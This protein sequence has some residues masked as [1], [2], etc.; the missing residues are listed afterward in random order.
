MLGKVMQ[1]GLHYEIYEDEG[2]GQKRLVKQAE[3]PHFI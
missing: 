1:I 3:Y 2:V